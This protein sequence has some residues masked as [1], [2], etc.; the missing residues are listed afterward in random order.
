METNV[1]VC[2]VILLFAIV[3]LTVKVGLMDDRLDK[4]EDPIEDWDSEE[5]S[6]PDH[7]DDDD[8]CNHII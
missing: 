4:L 5:S 1:T 8:P 6:P 7:T 3:V 2:F